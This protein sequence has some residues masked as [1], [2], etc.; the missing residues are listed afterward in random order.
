LRT[1]EKVEVK[2]TAAKVDV[3]SGGKRREREEG[4]KGCWL[5]ST[6][7]M[8]EAQPVNCRNVVNFEEE[9]CRRKRGKSRGREGRGRRSATF[10]VGSEQLKLASLSVVRFCRR[11]EV[12]RRGVSG[13]E[14]VGGRALD[15]ARWEVVERRHMEVLEWSIRCKQ[16]ND[17][18]AA[19]ER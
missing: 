16:R 14:G 12:R 13:G 6:A 18:V 19:C 7:R 2:T 5:L 8:K 4:E 10:I 11:R 3:P 15:W 9:T 1:R 17:V